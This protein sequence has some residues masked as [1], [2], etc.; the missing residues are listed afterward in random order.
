MSTEHRTNEHV[1]PPYNDP[2]ALLD[3][4]TE[5]SLLS[6]ADA[7]QARQD[8]RLSVLERRVAQLERIVNHSNGEL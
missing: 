2:A 7:H 6:A 1:Y 8:A 3:G 5:V 4:A